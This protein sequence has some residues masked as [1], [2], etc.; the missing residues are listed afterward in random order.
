MM[1]DNKLDKLIE[2]NITEARSLWLATLPH[3]EELPKHRFTFEFCYRI[4]RMAGMGYTLSYFLKLV[5]VGLVSVF[6]GYI[7]M[8]FAIIPMAPMLFLAFN[9]T[10]ISLLGAL[11]GIIVVPLLVYFIEH[12]WIWLGEWSR[13]REIGSHKKTVTVVMALPGLMS[14]TYAL[15]NHFVLPSWVIGSALYEMFSG[16]IRIFAVLVGHSMYTELFFGGSS[17]LWMV[18]FSAVFY[19]GI[20]DLPLKPFFRPLYGMALF[21]GLYEGALVLRMPQLLIWF[22]VGHLLTAIWTI[23]GLAV[24][25]HMD[26][27]KRHILLAVALAGAVLLAFTDLTDSDEIAPRDIPLFARSMEDIFPGYGDAAISMKW[28]GSAVALNKEQQTEVWA[29]LGM[30]DLWK[31]KESSSSLLGG[32][33]IGSWSGPI[34][35]KLE[36]DDPYKPCTLTIAQV[37]AGQN[38]AANRVYRLGLAFENGEEY[39]YIGDDPSEL[40]LTFFIELPKTEA[41]NVEDGIEAIFTFDLKGYEGEISIA[42]NILISTTTSSWDIL[43]VDSLLTDSTYTFR[44]IIP[45][46]TQYLFIR[47]PVF[48]VMK[49]K[50]DRPYWENVEAVSYRFEC[51]ADV[52]VLDLPLQ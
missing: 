40:P 29:Q 21:A 1:D 31:M 48:Y 2:Q 19:A 8:F 20:R 23:Y 52:M 18:L 3:K 12:L 10:F 24:A 51:E 26:K 34:H 28:N 46:G 50:D 45:E 42:Q 39:I 11:S 15:S 16:S 49:I 9:D 44:C 7:P 25:I 47:P 5:G 30:I 41:I 27:R 17:L 43:P 4:R 33:T 13:S 14:L 38:H 22:K 32:E 35:I 37:Q 36:I 6:L